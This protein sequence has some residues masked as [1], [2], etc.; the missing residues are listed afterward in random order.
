M[1]LAIAAAPRMHLPAW[2]HPTVAA[3]YRMAGLLIAA[4]VPALFWTLALMLVTKGTDI[5]IGVRSLAAFGMAVAAWCLV[6]AALVM[7][8]RKVVP[9]TQRGRSHRRRGV[10]SALWHRVD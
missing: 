3:L 2:S 6:A 4:G 7:G 1:K 9:L 8:K 5:A 10:R